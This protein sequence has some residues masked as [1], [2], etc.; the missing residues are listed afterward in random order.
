MGMKGGCPYIDPG[1]EWDWIEKSGKENGD[2]SRSRKS[3]KIIPGVA[4]TSTGHSAVSMNAGALR[5]D[6]LDLVNDIA[7]E[8]LACI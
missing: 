2:G 7:A 6:K 4:P 8:P 1:I 5:T 3:V